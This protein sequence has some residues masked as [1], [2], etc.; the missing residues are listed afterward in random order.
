[1]ENHLDLG[2]PR[3]FVLMISM[4]RAWFTGSLALHTT[5]PQHGAHTDTIPRHA[6]LVNRWYLTSVLWSVDMQ[7]SKQ[8]IRWR[9][10]HDQIENPSAELIEVTCF[11][12]LTA[13]QVMGFHWMAGSS[14]LTNYQKQAK[15]WTWLF[16]V[17]FLW[18]LS[19]LPYSV[20]SHGSVVITQWCVEIQTWKVFVKIHSIMGR[21]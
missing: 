1:M 12:K 16:V 11:L 21:F 20:N 15:I 8:V 4:L 6:S 10:S 2:E 9:V 5:S 18:W 14:I 7:L 3:I 19:L 17:Y 13:D